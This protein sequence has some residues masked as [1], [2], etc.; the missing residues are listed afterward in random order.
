[1]DDIISL[2]MDSSLKGKIAVITGASSGIGRA[3]ALKF[4]ACQ[5]KVVLIARDKQR[6]NEVKGLIQDQ[7]RKAFTFKADLTCPEEI[8]DVFTRIRTQV[9]HP[10]ILVNSAGI[11]SLGKAV[12]DITAED[13]QQ[14]FDI[15]VRAAFLVIP[16]VLPAM[17]K[18]KE[19]TI[20]NIGSISG[21]IGK[22][23][24][25]LYCASKFALAGMT[26][27]LL[28]EV[29]AYNIRVS[30]ISPE[31]VHSK[32]IQPEDI[33]EAALLCVSSTQTATIKE[34]IIRTRRPV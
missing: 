12:I 25:S 8:K 4:A 19:G 15:N 24:Q 6:L 1:M 34:I 18:A 20:I 27:A 2:L 33:A 22:A 32:F 3:I 10:H 28:E 29:R 31:M 21:K 16:Q 30:L 9:G 23:N 17:I 26:E 13:Y 14:I 5:A 7:G 11:G